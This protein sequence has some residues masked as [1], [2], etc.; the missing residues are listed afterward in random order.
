MFDC[1]NY[2]SKQGIDSHFAFDRAT[3]DS[4]P[5]INLEIQTE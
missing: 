1:V 5:N 4:V 2:R 3:F